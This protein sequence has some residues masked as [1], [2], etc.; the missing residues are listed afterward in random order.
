MRRS[1]RTHI[2]FSGGNSQGYT[3]G[4]YAIPLQGIGDSLSGHG[5]GNAVF[6]IGLRATSLK[7][8]AAKPLIRSRSP[9]KNSFGETFGAATGVSDPRLQ[10]RL[11]RLDGF[12]WAGF[13]ETGVEGQGA[14][15]NDTFVCS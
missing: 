13:W 8:M 10:G 14:G 7:T 5:I 11:C 6:T 1:F 15:S 4:W 3:L 12:F 2:A 9:A